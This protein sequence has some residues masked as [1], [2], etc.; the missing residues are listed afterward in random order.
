MTI[1]FVWLILLILL[2]V[3]ALAVFAQDVVFDLVTMGLVSHSVREAVAV[4]A[5]LGGFIFGAVELFRMVNR[6]RAAKDALR[7]ASGAFAEL[8]RDRFAQWRLTSAE[9]DV[10][11]LTLKGFETSEISELRHTAQ[12][13]VRAQ[14]TRIYAKA[15]MNSRGQFISS[16]IDQL[17]DKPLTETRDSG[18]KLADAS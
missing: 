2:Q 3:T 4:L 5:L 10:A 6:L 8:I 12:G 9:A 15:G 7:M 16:F 1:R 11:L 14:L 17:L 13:T 18:F